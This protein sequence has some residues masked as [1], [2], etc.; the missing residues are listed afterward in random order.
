[1]GTGAGGDGDGG[2]S[3]RGG[4]EQEVS[5]RARPAGGGSI[6][7]F[8]RS[9]RGGRRSG[10]GRRRSGRAARLRGEETGGSNRRA[11]DNRTEAVEPGRGGRGRSWRIEEV[12]AAAGCGGGEPGRAAAAATRGEERNLSL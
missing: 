7:L 11:G 10:W 6:R 9:I 12:A 5:A 2:R 1:V 3:D 4:R 8:E